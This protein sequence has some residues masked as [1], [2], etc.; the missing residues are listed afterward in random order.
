MNSE[1][2]GVVR[3]VA[4]RERVMDAM[5]GFL[6]KKKEKVEKTKC[7]SLLYCSAV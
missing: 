3:V 7:L 6:F 5:K 1:R 4:G 2:G